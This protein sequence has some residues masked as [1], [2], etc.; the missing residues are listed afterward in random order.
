[1]VDGSLKNI[2]VFGQV[3]AAKGIW[4]MFFNNGLW[5]KVMRFKYLGGT[6]V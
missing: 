4:R 5:S 2:Y 1:M 6:L 3:L